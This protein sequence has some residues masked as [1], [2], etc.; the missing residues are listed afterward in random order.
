MFFH[1]PR[2]T[3]KSNFKG[4][5]D[6]KESPLNAFVGAGKNAKKIFLPLK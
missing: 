4:T 6:H 2:A 3:S 5:G 1:H